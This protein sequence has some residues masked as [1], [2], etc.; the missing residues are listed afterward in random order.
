M[1]E[2]VFSVPTDHWPVTCAQLVLQ[3]APTPLRWR[4]ETSTAW[5]CALVS[6]FTRRSSRPLVVS[7][8]LKPNSRQ[9]AGVVQLESQSIINIF[10]FRLT[11]PTS[12]YQAAIRTAPL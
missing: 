9:F 11:S 5:S 12:S 6:S 10:W 8:Q 7:G 1:F 4:R 3:L 2:A